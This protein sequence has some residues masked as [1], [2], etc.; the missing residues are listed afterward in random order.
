MQQG[1]ESRREVV[2]ADGAGAGARLDRFLTE[3]LTDF[4]RS[5]LQALIRTGNVR[6][7]GKLVADPGTA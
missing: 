2:A 3:R 5:R 4:S 7:N 6:L 1:G